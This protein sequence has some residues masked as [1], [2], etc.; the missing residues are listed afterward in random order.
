MWDTS[1][2][3][4]IEPTSQYSVESTTGLP[5]S[6]QSFLLV[7]KGKESL[8]IHPAFPCTNCIIG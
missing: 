2:P 7:N 5:G 1:S 6:L 8:H 3:T 4:R